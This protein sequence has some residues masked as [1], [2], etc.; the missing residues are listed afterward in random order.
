MGTY[1]PQARQYWLLTYPRTSSNLL[2]KILGLEEQPNIMQGHV[3]GGYFF[4][5]VIQLMIELNLRGRGVH[6][7]TEDERKQ[8]KECYQSCFN[9]LHQHL[10]DAKKKGCSVF[11]KEH[12][13][14]MAH[15]ASMTKELNGLIVHEEPWTIEFPEIYSQLTTRSIQN[16]TVLP[17]GF[18]RQWL[19]TFLIRH[20]ALAF[21]SRYRASLDLDNA[22]GDSIGGDQGTLGMTLHWTRLLYEWYSHNLTAEEAFIDGDATWPL[23]LDGDDV[24]ANQGVVLRFGEILQLDTTKMRFSWKPVPEEQ[25]AKL[26]MRPKRMLSTLLDSEGIIKGKTAE[27]LD[28]DV[29]VKKWHNEFGGKVAV[30]LEELV[31]AAMPDYEFLKLRKLK[32]KISLPAV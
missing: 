6:E 22:D 13:H 8:M 32:A 16:E 26:E 1:Q 21:P 7:W 28:I 3:Q 17:D 27:N 31:R 10:E 24:M 19:P 29:E 23:V 18:L 30:R 5:P 11:V 12:C 20:P 25:R 9:T 4:L 2:V 15:P 14:F